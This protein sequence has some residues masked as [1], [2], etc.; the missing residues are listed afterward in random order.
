MKKRYLLAFLPLCLLLIGCKKKKD[1]KVTNTT[2]EEV[3][4][5]VEPDELER[6][7]YYKKDGDDV[8]ILGVKVK[9]AVEIIVPE[10]VT[11]I[12]DDDDFDGFRYLDNLQKITLPSTL[13]EIDDYSFSGC[14]KLVEIYNLSNID[15]KLNDEND[16]T[17]I[18]SNAYAIHK[19]LSESSNIVRTYGYSFIH[20]DTVSMLFDYIGDDLVLTTP[21][22]YTHNGTTV[23]NYDIRRNAFSDDDMIKIELSDAVNVIESYAFGGCYNLS[24]VTVGKNVTEIQSHAF[25]SDDRLDDIHTVGMRNECNRLV[26]VIN[27]SSLNI[28]KGAKTNGRIAKNAIV[29]KG[30]S[31][32]SSIVIKNNFVFLKTDEDTYLTC[33]FGNEE[34]VITP[35]S[36]IYNDIVINSYIL[37]D[38][39]LAYSKNIKRLVISDSATKI[40]LGIIINDQFH[41]KNETVEE[42][43]IGNNVTFIQANAFS[44]SIHLKKLTLGCKVKDI[45]NYSFAFCNELA[46]VVILSEETLILTD[47]SF[48]KTS[49]SDPIEKVFFKG[50][51]T[52]WDSWPENDKGYHNSQLFD[53][54]I[55]FY[56]P[57]EPIDDGNYWHYVDDR[58]TIW[59][60]V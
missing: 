53:A 58:I 35:D 50:A 1:S 59:E 7:F 60:E 46:D 43:I 25:G 33:Y 45:K 26:E 10:G 47:H 18:T 3:P 37:N 30:E 32:T 34:D 49:S 19:S 6:N 2:A 11:K 29:V 36:F 55:Y 16:Y 48:D 21:S 4:D 54:T 24:S 40:G 27:K 42:I 8:I 9:D 57:D 39:S 14:E 44:S 5:K 17:R 22:S 13:K 15:L 52:T 31:D 20:T 51:K 38:Y 28:E 23:S 12:V 56:S 41:K